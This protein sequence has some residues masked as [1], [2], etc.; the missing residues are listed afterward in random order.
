MLM[1]LFHILDLKCQYAH[2]LLETNTVGLSLVPNKLVYYTHYAFVCFCVYSC[3]IGV[4][5]LSVVLCLTYLLCDC[6]SSLYTMLCVYDRCCHGF[7]VA[8]PNVFRQGAKTTIDVSLPK[9][10]Y[11]VFVVGELV[12]AGKTVLGPVES[13]GIQFNQL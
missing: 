8:V 2:A 6:V 10:E 9:M 7:L 5:A 3:T 13:T 1:Q 4:D 12:K 11:A